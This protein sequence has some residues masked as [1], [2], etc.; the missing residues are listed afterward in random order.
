MRRRKA[1]CDGKSTGSSSCSVTNTVT[2]FFLDLSFSMNTRWTYP[3][4]AMIVTQNSYCHPLLLILCD[5][6]DHG[7][8]LQDPPQH[9]A[10]GSCH[11]LIGTQGEPSLSRPEGHLLFQDSASQISVLMDHSFCGWFSISNLS[12]T[13]ICKINKNELIF[14]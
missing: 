10:P 8:W 13:Y 11:Q 1:W 12:Q 5:T 4:S 6:T 14:F 3:Q 2:F 9:G 7:P